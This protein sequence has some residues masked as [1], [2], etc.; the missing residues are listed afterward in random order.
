MKAKDKFLHKHSKQ[1]R[2]MPFWVCIMLWLRK[3]ATIFGFIFLLIGILVGNWIFGT[4]EKIKKLEEK[5][6][7][8]QG[9]VTNVK[10][11]EV[12]R[13]GETYEEYKCYYEFEISPGRKIKN[14]GDA[15]DLKKGDSI[16]VKYNP[17]NPKEA[18]IVGHSERSKGDYL[19]LMFPFL[20]IMAMFLSLIQTIA[21][22]KV[23]KNGQLTH[24][25]Y[26][27]KET[28]TGSVNGDMVYKMYF[29]FTA[30]NGKEYKIN[31]ETHRTAALQDD[32]KEII[33]FDLKNP[34]KAYPLD[35]LPEFVKRFFANENLVNNKAN[36][37]VTAN[38]I[39]KNAEQ[40]HSVLKHK[41]DIP[42]S[43]GISL[44]F[45]NKKNAIFGIAFTFLAIFGSI[46]FLNYL[47]KNIKSI[48]DSDPVTQCVIT[49]IE[50][51]ET[52]INGESVY[53]YYFK[54]NTKSGEKIKSS[55]FYSY[56][57]AEIGDT[58]Q[59]QYNSDKPTEVRFTKFETP[60]IFIMLWVLIPFFAVGLGLLIVGIK[61]AAKKFR[62]LKTGQLVYATYEGFTEV[63]EDDDDSSSVEHV[64]FKFTA[65]NGKEYTAIKITGSHNYLAEQQK[66]LV[67][68]DLKNP[69]NSYVV[70]MLPKKAQKYLEKI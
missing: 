65:L 45:S 7:V 5:G 15:D 2:H 58:L 61:G 48:D 33:V 41:R 51:T 53:K 64:Y 26:E 9:I 24:G 35:A 18:I 60:N 29:K 11:V 66:R 43:V 68:Y 16:S 25:I 69:D 62:I 37:E 50:D 34:K 21:K 70:D 4:H 12:T 1:Q 55:A 54:F 46:P 17:A 67:I 42:V 63:G 27:G 47:S 22:F 36:A 13:D 49:D 56:G 23:L 52:A 3:P 31:T 10:I 6:I 44:F 19:I 38:S 8:A 39:N 28:T 32:E 59:V 30:P 20:G 40:T 57:I 14:I